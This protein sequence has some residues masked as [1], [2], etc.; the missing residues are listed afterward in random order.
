MG[1]PS[2]TVF[3][4][5]GN[6]GE[7]GGADVFKMPASLANVPVMALAALVAPS[8]KN[9]T[10]IQREG[11]VVW[12][13]YGF[14]GPPSLTSDDVVHVRIWDTW[15]QCNADNWV[16]ISFICI[17]LYFDASLY[18]IR[19]RVAT[20]VYWTTPGAEKVWGG[21]GSDNDE[22]GGIYY[23]GFNKSSLLEFKIRI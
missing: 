12:I 20:K 9:S 4:S 17:S 16:Y 3:L 21:F 8:I 18:C 7:V 11:A 22:G 1:L 6:L 15:Q 10:I 2:V 13:K 19:F 23:C 5:R 14:R